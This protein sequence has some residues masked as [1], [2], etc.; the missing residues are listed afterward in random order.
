ML[1][2]YYCLAR[3]NT[4]A[5]TVSDRSC[6]LRLIKLIGHNIMSNLSSLDAVHACQ[7]CCIKLLHALGAVCSQALEDIIDL[8]IPRV[9]TSG[10]CP[11]AQEVRP[12]Q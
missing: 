4:L 2:G 6:M 9:L 5:V 11:S 8:G 12:S 1:Q 3:S 10:G 7:P